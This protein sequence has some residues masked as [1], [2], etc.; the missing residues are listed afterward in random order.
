MQGMHVQKIL[1]S[2]V[3]AVLVA[4]VLVMWTLALA[5]PCEAG[6]PTSADAFSST[7]EGRTVTIGEVTYVP[8]ATEQNADGKV[9]VNKVSDIQA[10]CHAA[11]NAL[12]VV[13]ALLSLTLVC[14][15]ASFLRGKTAITW[16]HIVNM[17]LIVIGFFVVETMIAGKVTEQETQSMA[18]QAEFEQKMKATGKVVYAVE[19]IPQGQ[20]IPAEVLEERVLEQSK[21]PHDAITSANL[22]AGRIAKYGIFTGQIVSLHDLAPLRN[23]PQQ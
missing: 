16:R 12:Q 23:P 21:I 3:R 14:R 22:V 8:R 5:S 18:K 13:L 1:A 2:N 15:A 4:L 7:T 20:E 19:D 6:V 17:L 10:L 11:T 9:R